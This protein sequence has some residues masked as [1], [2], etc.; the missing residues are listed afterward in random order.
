VYRNHNDSAFQFA[1]AGRHDANVI[2]TSA[3][4]WRTDMKLT[5]SHIAA[6]LAAA[7]ALGTVGVAFAADEPHPAPVPT[8]K[9]EKCYGIVKAGKNDCQTAS[10]S[11]AGTSRRD[12][13]KDAWVYVPAGVC[14]KLVGG[15]T[16]RS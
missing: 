3:N 10:S 1:V 14:G 4:H 8:F 13:Q 12:G 6:T 2:S 15:S 5:T 7:V 16:S 9:S 11:C